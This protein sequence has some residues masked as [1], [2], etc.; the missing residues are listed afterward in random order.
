LMYGVAFMLIII[1]ALTFLMIMAW[2]NNDKYLC[3]I[4]FMLCINAIADPQLLYLQY[5]PF[6]L[7]VGIFLQNYSKQKMLPDWKIGIRRERKREK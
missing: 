7:L 3:L 1:V 5:N 2:R 6:I 4:I